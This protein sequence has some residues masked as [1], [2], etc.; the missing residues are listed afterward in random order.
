MRY[1]FEVMQ[2]TRHAVTPAGSEWPDGDTFNKFFAGATRM[3]EFLNGAGIIGEPEL[4]ILDVVDVP[5]TF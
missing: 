3:G 4:S 5:G 1:L 2:P